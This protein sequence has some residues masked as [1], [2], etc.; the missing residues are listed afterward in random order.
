M[1]E[2]DWNNDRG[3]HL[4]NTEGQGEEGE[5]LSASK[6]NEDD[7]VNEEEQTGGENKS[8]KGEIQNGSE[9]EKVSETEVLENPEDTVPENKVPKFQTVSYEYFDDALFIGDSRTVGLMEYGNLENATFFADSGMSVYGLA[10][11]K[12]SV[13]G[14]GKVT[15]DE[16]LTEQQYGK[17]YLMLG[18]N[19]LGYRFDTTKERYQET[20]EKILAE[21]E[22]AI[23][24]LCA[25]MHVTAEQSAKDEIYNNENVNLINELIAGLT[26]GEKIFYLDVNELFD[27][28]NGALAE[29]YTSDA[30]HVLGKYYE[31]WIDWLCTRAILLP[32]EE[33][34]GENS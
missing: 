18:M 23:I 26:D 19:E 28:E 27:D 10:W 7:E 13:P 20:L 4:V 30:F 32:E 9:T 6:D 3:Q 17:I 5:Q 33:Q 14:K 12:I 34:K 11:K 24:Y 15:F 22:N 1:L 21:Q 8:S 16:I 31:D 29:E 25:N 2:R